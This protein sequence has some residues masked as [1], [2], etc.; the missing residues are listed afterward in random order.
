MT[1]PTN[2]H[3]QFRTVDQQLDWVQ[4]TEPLISMAK[5]VCE[6]TGPCRMGFNFSF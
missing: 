1:S 4:V 3:Y 5:V 6:D 2:S